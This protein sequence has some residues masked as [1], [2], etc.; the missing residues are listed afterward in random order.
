MS[1][2]SAIYSAALLVAIVSIFVAPTLAQILGGVVGLGELP[3]AGCIDP[4]RG[5]EG[6]T[7]AFMTSVLRAPIQQIEACCRIYLNISDNCWPK[8]YPYNTPFPLFVKSYCMTRGQSMTPPSPT[9]V[10]ANK[11]N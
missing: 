2:D 1:R 3:G 7:Q 4:L 11:L 9:N 6:C 8:M 10:R 5:I